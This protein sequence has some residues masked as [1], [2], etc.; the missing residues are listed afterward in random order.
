LSDVTLAHEGSDDS[1]SCRT[2]HPLIEVLPT[3]FVED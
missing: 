2:R 1:P 3:C